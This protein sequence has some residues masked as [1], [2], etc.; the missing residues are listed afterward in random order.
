MI[1]KVLPNKIP[2]VWELIKLTVNKAS[3]LQ[4]HEETAYL[5]DLLHA[6]LS[7][8]AQAFIR[9]DE[10]KENIKT[11]VLTRIVDDGF[12]KARALLIENYYAFTKSSIE[13]WESNMNFSIEFAR[14]NNCSIIRVGSINPK[15]IDLA[16][17]F[18][19]KKKSIILDYDIGGV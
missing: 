19:Y 3:A 16:L 12:T 8:N 5:N 10:T 4:D 6:L 13:E 9:T 18:G 17:H 15:I 11:V 1:F 2:E 7:G 14:K